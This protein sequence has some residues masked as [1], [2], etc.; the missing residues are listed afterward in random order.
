MKK[1]IRYKLLNLKYRSKTHLIIFTENNRW[2]NVTGELSLHHQLLASWLVGD[3]NPILQIGGDYELETLCSFPRSHERFLLTNADILLRCDRYNPRCYYLDRTEIE[4]HS[5]KNLKYYKEQFELNSYG[6][7]KTL[8]FIRAL[9]GTA[10]KYKLIKKNTTRLSENELRNIYCFSDP[11][12]RVH[13]SFLKSDGN[14]HAIVGRG[15]SRNEDDWKI[16]NKIE[17]NIFPDHR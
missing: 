14:A 13:I 9:R 4:N 12:T 15:Y 7:M 6:K 2:L 16:I 17:G 10:S 3:S 11:G 5:E 1:E 8:T